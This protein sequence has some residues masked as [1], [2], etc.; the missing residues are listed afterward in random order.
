MKRVLNGFMATTCRIPVDHVGLAPAAG[1]RGGEGPAGEG[2]A[3]AAVALL[4]AGREQKVWPILQHRPDP[5]TRSHLVHR[6]RPL[7]RDPHQVLD[8][9]DTQGEVSIRREL[10]LILGEFSHQQLPPVNASW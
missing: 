9:L 5:R 8:Q 7:D 1:C 10:I 2:Q 6:F 4:T 3:N